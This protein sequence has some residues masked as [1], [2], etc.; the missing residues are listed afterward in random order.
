M[1]EFTSLRRALIE[2]HA[3]SLSVPVEAF[4]AEATLLALVA[5]KVV[6]W[7]RTRR[8]VTVY[9]EW[10]E[11]NLIQLTAE[12]STATAMSIMAREFHHLL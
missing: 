9:R 11:R 7:L 5:A 8:F 10:K 4:L 3:L 6:A 1:S 12:F 2:H